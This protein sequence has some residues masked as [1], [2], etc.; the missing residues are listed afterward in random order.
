MADPIL[1]IH[2][3]ANRDEKAFRAVV[4]GLE[5]PFAGR[6]R[7]EPVYW[8]DLGAEAEFID[9]TLPLLEQVRAAQPLEADT[10]EAIAV[11]LLSSTSAP[12]AADDGGVR[13]GRAETVARAELVAAAAAGRSAAGWPAVRGDEPSALSPQVAAEVH[14][15]VL[16]EFPR[17]TWLREIADPEVLAALG[18]TIGQAVAE[19]PS[20]VSGQELR[21]PDVGKFAEDLLRGADRFT[22]AL[23]GKVGGSLNDT[24]RRQRGKDV[25][26]FLGDVLIYQR[27]R[28]AIHD[29]V[30]EAVGE[31]GPGLGTSERPVQVIGHS[32]GGVIAFDLAVAAD[33]PLHTR[34][35]LTFGSQSPLF[36][37]IDQRA[38]QLAKYAPG[39][40]VQLPST[41]AAWRNLWEPM[42]PLAFVAGKVFR[43]AD[44]SRPVDTPVRHLATFGLWT[45]SVYWKTAEL[46]G[47]IRDTFE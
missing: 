25:A 1:V 45:H 28:T 41:L 18:A 33:P 13:G 10:I 32:L 38:P 46:L 31:L 27:R 19:R 43:F 7:F 14:A 17:L 44:G 12:V 11:G 34:A 24:V 20:S 5:R 8:G 26:R 36:H 29:R 47:A 3:V 2:G 39:A 16:G 22:G 21:A 42:D 40:P 15:A 30:R 4:A 9:D 6:H 23:I 35:L 37:V